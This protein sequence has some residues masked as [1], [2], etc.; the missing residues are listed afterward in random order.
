MWRR[1]SKREAK[2]IIKWSAQQIT[3]RCFRMELPAIGTPGVGMAGIGPVKMDKRGP[4]AFVRLKINA[5]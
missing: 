4:F 1:S 5:T 3:D 2:Y